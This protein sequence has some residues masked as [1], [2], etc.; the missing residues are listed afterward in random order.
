ML[1]FC[2]HELGRSRTK[3]NAFIKMLRQEKIRELKDF[4]R[5]IVGK[6][7]LSF[8][9]DISRKNDKNGSVQ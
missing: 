4:V 8:V 5:N 9:N 7:G 6:N 1:M 3:K 2:L